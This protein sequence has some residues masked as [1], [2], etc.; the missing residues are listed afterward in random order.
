M[1]YNVQEKNGAFRVVEHDPDGR[2]WNLGEFDNVDRAI[3]FIE[4]LE[5]DTLL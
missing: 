4:E 3:E 2:V 1:K 5:K